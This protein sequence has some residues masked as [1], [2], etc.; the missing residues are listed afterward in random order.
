MKKLLL[1]FLLIIGFCAEAQ[2]YNNEWIDYNKTYYRF[3]VGVT[4]LH[5]IM[6]PALVNLGLNSTPVE[7]FQLWRNG[8][9]VPIYTSQQSGTLNAATDYIEFWAEMNDCKPDNILYR[10][11][12]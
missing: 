1:P 9:Q 12:D 5:R 11:P 6:Q 4:G 2:T 7:Q 3:R 8:K 10:H